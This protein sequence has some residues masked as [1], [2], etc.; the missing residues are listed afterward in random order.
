MVSPGIRA[1]AYVGMGVTGEVAYTA[2]KALIQ[3]RD[4]RL[5]G[6]TQLWVMPLYALGGVFIFEKL[7][8]LIGGWN[9]ALRFLV[10]AIVIFGIEYLAGFT[11]K[12]IT[13]KCPWE[14]QGKRSLHG[15]INLPHLPCWGA[16]G[17][18]FEHAHNYLITI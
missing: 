13:G 14:Y 10:Y 6:Y 12:Q 17:L 1:L 7:V 16:V 15:Y 9:I 5:Q 8:S 18:A 4:L 2:L 3:K 11:A